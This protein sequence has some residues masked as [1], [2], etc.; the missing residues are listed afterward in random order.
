MMNDFLMPS[1]SLAFPEFSYRMNEEKYIEKLKEVPSNWKCICVDGSSH[2][3]H[4]WLELIKAVD[5]WVLDRYYD[6]LEDKLST[7]GFPVSVIRKAVE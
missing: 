7:M 3:A 5:H 4:Q 2:D 6:V 1:L